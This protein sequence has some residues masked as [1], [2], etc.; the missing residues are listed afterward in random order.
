MTPLVV[1][2]PNA[3]IY[4]ISCDISRPF[5]C[6][7]TTTEWYE[8]DFYDK[9]GIIWLPPSICVV[10]GSV[11][12]ALWLLKFH[13]T[14]NF[15]HLSLPRFCKSSVELNNGSIHWDG[16]STTYFRTDL[17]RLSTVRLRLVRLAASR[18]SSRALMLTP[19]SLC[20][21]YSCTSIPDSAQRGY[22][23]KCI[24]D[25]APFLLA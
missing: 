18:F 14:L 3:P 24:A 1:Q 9:W 15:N 5:E 2:L 16:L 13:A 22:Y 25:G 4:L 21:P 7:N 23:Y 6:A 11:D 17:P 20:T 8:S 12:F 19:A 10:Y